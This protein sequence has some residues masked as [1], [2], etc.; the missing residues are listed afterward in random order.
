MQHA[1]QFDAVHKMHE[2]LEDAVQVGR[3]EIV[4]R[5]D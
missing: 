3:G 2:L 5:A 1:D 4:A